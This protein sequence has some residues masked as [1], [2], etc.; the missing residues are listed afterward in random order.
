[1]EAEITSE[2]LSIARDTRHSHS[3]SPLDG[4]M[5]AQAP[6]VGAG[7][8]PA[9]TELASTHHRNQHAVGQAAYL[10]SAI[11]IIRGT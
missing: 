6:S 7:L 9:P 1:V 3:P 10:R 4:Q 2:K 5:N 8:E 11:P